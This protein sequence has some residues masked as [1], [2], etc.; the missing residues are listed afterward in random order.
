MGGYA[1]PT[2]ARWVTRRRGQIIPPFSIRF[3]LLRTGR[4]PR[5]PSD[6]YKDLYSHMGTMYGCGGHVNENPKEAL[7]F[8]VDA[9]D[10]TLLSSKK[11]SK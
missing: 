10:L 4:S 5:S 9:V 6:E 2:G 8:Y 11:N 1:P 3:V 7:E